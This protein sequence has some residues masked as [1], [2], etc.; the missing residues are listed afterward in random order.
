[1]NY[2]FAN[3][4]F[5]FMV[6]YLIIPPI[7]SIAFKRKLYKEPEERSSHLLPTP[8]VGGVG[9]FAGLLL[10][11]L[12]LVPFPLIQGIQYIIGALVIIFLV[13]LKDDLDPTAARMKLLAQGITTALL[14]AFADI[15]LHSLH[16]FFN[17]SAD[18]P[19]SLSFL[20][21]LITIL[22][23]MNAFNLIDGI[24]G[25]SASLG[26]LALAIFGSW[27]YLTGHFL[28]AAIA[29]AAGG[30]Y[31]AFLPYNLFPPARTFMGDTG[32]LLLGTIL[33]ILAIQFIEFNEQLPNTSAYHLSAAPMVT[34]SIMAIPLFDTLR[35]FFT[36]LYRGS[37]PMAADR[38]HI[39][40]LLI[41]YGFSHTKATGLLFA[42]NLLIVLT[43]LI[44]QH[45]I[46]QHLLLALV[47]VIVFLP[48]Y[49][50]HKAVSRKK[51][52]LEQSSPSQ[53]RSES[54]PV[55]KREYEWL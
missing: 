12:F 16:G 9:I 43:V 14:I 30:A 49:F 2:L 28:Y 31:L 36:R 41:D 35:V 20:L 10:S 25:L 32:S 54:L 50:L 11:L 37:H 42:Y 44:G 22:M 3:A 6:T 18:L 5:A 51:S 27:F 39:H 8:A 26:T 15:R 4:I 53:H 7:L 34:V 38:R 1:M 48:V 13:G 23:I 24:N 19:Y 52:Q 29:A 33:A 47:L 45:Y 17:W 46:E 21:S 40:H 55:K